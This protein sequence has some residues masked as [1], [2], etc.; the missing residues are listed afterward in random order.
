MAPDSQMKYGEADFAAHRVANTA[1]FLERLFPI[2][3]AMINTIFDKV[4]ESGDYKNECWFSVS[5]GNTLG[6]CFVK[7]ANAIHCAAISVR[8]DNKEPLSDAKWMEYSS[9]RQAGDMPVILARRQA[10]AQRDVPLSSPSYC[11][12][13]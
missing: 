13:V 11:L 1:D 5:E 7:A 6:Q 2:S 3:N 8:K 4:T 12:D 9:A 10:Q